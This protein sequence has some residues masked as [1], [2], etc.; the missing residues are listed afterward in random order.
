MTIPLLWQ[1]T[2]VSS[3]PLRRFSFTL[4]RPDNP[5]QRRRSRG[6]RHDTQ[7]PGLFFRSPLFSFVL[8]SKNDESRAQ[9]GC[10]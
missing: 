7:I 8:T 2:P 10:L 6:A 5:D 9:S 4:F 3:G 1:E